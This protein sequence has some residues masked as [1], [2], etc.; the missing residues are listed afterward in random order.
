MNSYQIEVRGVT[1]TIWAPTL[2]EAVETFMIDM[3]F[4]EVPKEL[5]ACEPVSS[6]PMPENIPAGF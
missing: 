5:M 2:R 6:F 4:F 3:D 1:F